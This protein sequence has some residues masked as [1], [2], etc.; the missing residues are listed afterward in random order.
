MHFRAYHLNQT[1]DQETY[2]WIWSICWSSKFTCKLLFKE[3]LHSY[4]LRR[5]SIY[6]DGYSLLICWDVKRPS[7]AWLLVNIYY[8]FFHLHVSI[9]DITDQHVCNIRFHENRYTTFRMTYTFY[10]FE[11]CIPDLIIWYSSFLC[12]S[13]NSKTSMFLSELNFNRKSFLS[14]KRSSILIWQMLRTSSTGRHSMRLTVTSEST[15]MLLICMF[16]LS[17]CC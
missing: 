1:R 12:I 15:P 14:V 7:S 6:S 5:N 3:I 17:R 16:S 10:K 4:L 11:I 9:S 13:G 8:R 2:P